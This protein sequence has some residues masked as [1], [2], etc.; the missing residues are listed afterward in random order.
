MNTHTNINGHLFISKRTQI[1]SAFGKKINGVS[2][3]SF[4]LPYQYW[5]PH[6]FDPFTPPVEILMVNYGG[7]LYE[8][9]SIEI[10]SA[11]VRTLPLPARFL[12]LDFFTVLLL[13]DFVFVYLY[14]ILLCQEQKKGELFLGFRKIC[15]K[16]L[17][18]YFVCKLPHGGFILMCLCNLETH[19][20]QSHL[21][22]GCNKKCKYPL[23]IS[24]TRF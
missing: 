18:M 14:F 20:S 3:P 4:R 8:L 13:R 7:F 15:C 24:I 9:L 19:K 6:A 1:Y 2:P 12:K 17:L 23:Y 16:S 10:Y 21:L 5:Y 22:S 11:I